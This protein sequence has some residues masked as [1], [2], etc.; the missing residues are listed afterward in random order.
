MSF[1]Q[2]MSYLDRKLYD[3]SMGKEVFFE[4]S[5]VQITHPNI[6]IKSLLK[7]KNNGKLFSK[8]YQI[9]DKEF[10]ARCTFSKTEFKSISF[11][12]PIIDKK[13]MS[14]FTHK[15]QVVVECEYSN[16]GT[17]LPVVNSNGEKNTFR[18]ILS[19]DFDMKAPS[20]DEWMKNEGKHIIDEM[21]DIVVQNSKYILGLSKNGEPINIF[22][23]TRFIE[24]LENQTFN[25]VKLENDG[26]YIELQYDL[27]LKEQKQIQENKIEELIEKIGVPKVIL[28][29]KS[30]KELKSCDL[31]KFT[32][33]KGFNQP[34]QFGFHVIWELDSLISGK[35]HLEYRYLAK[36][37]A[38]ELGCDVA[39]NHDL[40]KN[41]YSTA[42]NKKY[43]KQ[44]QKIS[45]EN[46]FKKF[47]TDQEDVFY[48]NRLFDQ[49]SNTISS[50]EIKRANDI[51]S[52]FNNLNHYTLNEQN[53]QDRDKA[54]RE[55]YQKQGLKG[56]NQRFSGVAQ[57]TRN[58]SLYIYMTRLNGFELD[59]LSNQNVPA[60]IYSKVTSTNEMLSDE[61]FLTTK[62]SVLKARKY[63]NVELNISL[64]EYNRG[65]KEI[66]QK[67][68][69]QQEETLEE[70]EFV[71]KWNNISEH[72][73]LKHL[74]I[75]NTNID[76]NFVNLNFDKLLFASQNKNDF[77]M[78]FKKFKN[79]KLN[80][81]EGL[82]Q[83]KRTHKFNGQVK[84]D[85]P[86][87]KM[88]IFVRNLGLKFVVKN[89]TNFATDEFMDFA[90]KFIF[91]KFSDLEKDL[92]IKLFNASST[93]KFD[94]NKIVNIF[95]AAVS[96]VFNEEKQIY[97]SIKKS[98]NQIT[99]KEDSFWQLINNGKKVSYK[100]LYVKLFELQQET[101]LDLLWNNGKPKANK[102]IISV[103]G[104]DYNKTD[105]LLKEIK[106][107][108]SKLY[109]ESKGKIT[110][111]EI[112][113]EL[114]QSSYSRIKSYY[115]NNLNIEVEETIFNNFD[116][117]SFISK[118]LIDLKQANVKECQAT[119]L[120]TDWFVFEKLK[121]F[122]NMLRSKDKLLY[123]SEI[124]Q[125]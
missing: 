4:N 32:D 65:F 44:N 98:D 87:D 122:I 36:R 63:H 66:I 81:E 29:N 112:Y 38:E 41:V 7:K 26:Q 6:L 43:F 106:E 57:E 25:G 60:F 54:E 33:K 22:K 12:I 15:D 47:L 92:L 101:G 123:L 49:N 46:V 27:F 94:K 51:V 102:G 114:K 59:K 61:E 30:R 17:F 28:T 9:G 117:V 80:G 107:F 23:S 45:I 53:Q 72:L 19:M 68:P 1:N 34:K 99:L 2:F 121:E 35:Y 5:N 13:A 125:T 39:F 40:M 83:V 8:E 88:V 24:T 10:C 89:I 113:N 90:N 11:Y 115:S 78:N 3:M 37:L 97:N 74:E 31:W 64:D 42:F 96:I 50:K 21:D 48:I 62:N 70:I 100:D 82:F 93:K 71:D 118:N 58:N 79:L 124:I 75:T 108:W 20:I 56:F 95:N 103:L 52:F 76:K 85:T 18:N 105:K 110:A 116:V 55:F 86:L 104:T 120:P 84:T 14:I 91:T 119:A 109:N 77:V 111:E 67:K 16:K 73:I 69:I